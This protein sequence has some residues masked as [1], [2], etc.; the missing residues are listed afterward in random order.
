MGAGAV[1]KGQ[2]RIYLYA[3]ANG[4]TVTMPTLNYTGTASLFCALPYN[5]NTTIQVTGNINLGSTSGNFYNYGATGTVFDL[6]GHSLTCGAFA[7]GSGGGGGSIALYYRN[8]TINCTSF[9]GSSFNVGP[10]NEYFGA[11]TIN[12]S[13][14][15]TIG[16]TH[17]VMSG[18]ETWNITG[19]S[20][21]TTNGK[22][23]GTINFKPGTL[24]I[25][26]GGNVYCKYYW[27]LG[28]ISRASYSIYGTY[29]IA[30]EVKSRQVAYKTMPT[31]PSKHPIW[32]L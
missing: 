27:I 29:I 28:K 23:L 19:T 15:V 20:T 10:C 3:D 12:C 1:W 30:N 14:A 4:I 8:S 25:T 17:T 31:L 32:T 5:N 7:S 2:S 16:S 9:N 11:C 22:M 26:L 6:N 18:N 24:T 21:I 13:G